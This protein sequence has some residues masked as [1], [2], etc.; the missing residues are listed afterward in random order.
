MNNDLVNTPFSARYAPR[1]MVC[2]TDHL[3][4]GAGVALLRKGGSAADAAIG[5]SAVLAV[6]SQHMCGVGGDLWALVHVPGQPRPFALNA[7]GR[8]GSGAD[9]KTITADALSSMPFHKDPRSVPVPGCVDGWLA[10]HQKFGR[11]PLEEVLADAI[12][13]A[14][15][16]FPISAECALATEVLEGVEYADDY[17]REGMPKVGKL[18][19]RPGLGKILEG[20]TS[21]NRE[22]F[23]LGA[24]GQELMDFGRGEYHPEDLS[25]SQAEWV[26]PLSVDAFGH[27]IWGL[28]P[29]SQGY[30]C[31]AAAWIADQIGVPRAADHPDFWHLLVE[32]SLQAAY[33]RPDVLHEHADGP[34]LLAPSRLAPRAGDIRLDEIASLPTAANHGDT[35]YLNAI[36]ESR[37]GV[38]LIQS[39]ASG[40][41]ALVFLPETGV[42]L[43]NRGIGFSVDPASRAA[44]GP[45]RRPPHTLAPTLVEDSAA[46]LVALVGTMGGDS[47]PQIVLQLLARLLVA[48]QDPAQALAARRWRLSGAQS[49]GFN[50]WADPSEVFL[51]VEDV[52][53]QLVENLATR[54]H[55]I[56]SLGANH[57]AF[58][59][60]HIIKVEGGVLVGAAEPRVSTSA[61]IA[62]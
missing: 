15:D 40:W 11:L 5:A 59:H 9:I 53:P 57:S 17:L 33:D 31:L 60:A 29:N 1:G 49:N 12:T 7:S 55:K 43:H 13:L 25:Q 38:S 24:F 19:K 37:M 62:H 20:L 35:I 36:D 54:G 18:I 34:L 8:S 16:G 6:T 23:Y 32:A 51:E 52:E 4:S 14:S 42:S 56:R 58:G 3:A 45:K 21:G 48:G 46:Q 27:K 22:T 10:L 61:A 39:N 50:T 41:G 30:L 44:Y 47:Q 26:V 28:P 2:S